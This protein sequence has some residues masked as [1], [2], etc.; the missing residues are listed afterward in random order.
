MSNFTL[1]VSKPKSAEDFE[2][3]CLHVYCVVFSDALPS[4]NGRSGQAQGGVD[5]FVHD[6]NAGRI[7]IQC[8]RYWESALT[9]AMIDNEI[10]EADQR[11]WQMVQ[12]IIATTLLADSPLEQYIQK[13]SDMREAQGKFKVKIEFWPN[14]CSHINSHP[15]LQKIYSPNSPNGM[16]TEIRDRFDETQAMQHKILQGVETLKRGPLHAAGRL[17]PSSANGIEMLPLLKEKY[18]RYLKSNIL[19]IKFLQKADR[20]MLEMTV[21]E[22]IAGYLTNEITTRTDLGFVAGGS[23]DGYYFSPQRSVLENSIRFLDDSDEISIINCTDIFT[24][25]AAT[26]IDAY[27]RE[28]GAPPP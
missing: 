27:W 17:E 1:E 3:Y 10:K 11:G 18:A 21:E 23:D 8:K 13:I 12:L 20:C 15:S 14:I 24:H 4:N 7:G 5:L 6:K 19:S 22:H 28:H 26:F 9:K 16:F 25:E 2:S